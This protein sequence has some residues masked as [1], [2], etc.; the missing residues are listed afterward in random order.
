MMIAVILLT[1]RRTDYAL[2]AIRSL[3]KNLAGVPYTWIMADDGSHQDHWHTIYQELY[4]DN[5]YAWRSLREGYGAG[6][7][8]AWETSREISPVTLWLEDDWELRYPLDVSPY[9]RLLT[10]HSDIGCVRLGHLPIDLELSSIGR[11]GRMYLNV[12]KSTQ[13]AFSGNPHLKHTRFMDYGM[14]PTGMNPGN[15]EVA[16]DYQIRTQEGPQIIWPLAIGE[17][18][19]WSHIGEVQSYETT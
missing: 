16:Y 1:F 2:R 9:V 17:N 5:L 19:P 3:Q 12:H 18:P 11:E 4:H 7:N 14:Y 10:H 13:Y 15:T 8:W 6:A